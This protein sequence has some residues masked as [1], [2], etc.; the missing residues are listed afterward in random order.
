[1]DMQ[2]LKALS[3]SYCKLPHGSERAEAI[4][5][6]IAQADLQQDHDWRFH[7]RDDLMMELAFHGDSGTILPII[8][9]M[10]AIYENYPIKDSALDYVYALYICTEQWDCLPQLPLCQL[11]MMMERFKKAVEQCCL[12]DKSYHQRCWQIAIQ[13][14]KRELAEQAYQKMLQ[15]KFRDVSSCKACKY[16]FQTDYFLKTG[17]KEKAL[18][19]AQPMAE[20][21]YQKMLQPKFRDVS[22]CKACKYH[23]QTDYFLKTGQKEK[24][25]Q[26]AQPILDGTVTCQSEPERTLSSF[27]QFALDYETHEQ[28]TYWADL[29]RPQLDKNEYHSAMLRW[30]AYHDTDKA[31]RML[32]SGVAE[33]W[34]EWD[35]EEV[36]GLCTAAWVVCLQ[37]NKHSPEQVVLTLPKSFPLWQENGLYAMDTLGTF[38]YAHAQNIAR[39]FDTRNN[40]HYYQNKLLPK[41]FPLWQ[42]N[43]LYA[44]DTL[45]TFFYAHAQ[46][47]ARAFDTRNNSHYYQNKLDNANHLAI[48]RNIL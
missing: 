31:L 34:G 39:A 2:S 3:Q 5:S 40:S 30:L 26:A 22:S 24:A 7:M 19:A 41:S 21:A 20:Q 9:E 6:A 8:S 48:E 4:R 17:Q 10:I 32:E 16:H 28:A 44:M 45:G 42:E 18:Q 12:G 13:Q 35:Q 29:L 14:E 1:M 25:L 15:P 33:V 23:F 43:G 11:D 47:I 38:F 37:Y 36:F 46:N 27:L